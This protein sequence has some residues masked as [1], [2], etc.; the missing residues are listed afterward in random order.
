MARFICGDAVRGVRNNIQGTVTEVHVGADS[1][2][3][4]L[5]SDE[6]ELLYA[7]ESELIPYGQAAYMHLSGTLCKAIRNVNMISAKSSRVSTA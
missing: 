6:K 3:Y 7:C 4:T 5:I 1:I 2:G